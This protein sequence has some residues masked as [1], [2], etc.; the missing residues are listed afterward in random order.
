MN[1]VLSTIHTDRLDILQNVSWIRKEENTGS[2]DVIISEQFQE[3]DDSIL[4]V[5][6]NNDVAT[7]R[8][9]VYHYPYQSTLHEYLDSICEAVR[10]K[11]AVHV[12]GDSHSIISHKIT[13]CRENWLGFN[14]NY[15]LTMFRFGNE[16]LHLHD[17]IKIVGNGHEKYPVRKGDIVMYSYGEIDARYLI[18]KHCNHDD[19]ADHSWTGCHLKEYRDIH[20]LTDNLINN[21]MK[22]IKIN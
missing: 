4:Q 13:I 5:I 22:Q 11:I 1:I 15:P 6:F 2:Y 21:Y 14:T 18:L 10:N 17:C 3:R 19:T 20:T 8:N 16:G 9:N 12:F 7:E